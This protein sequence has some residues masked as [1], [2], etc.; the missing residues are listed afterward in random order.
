MVE[1]IELT[2]LPNGLRIV[3]ETVPHVQSVSVGI[4]VGVGERDEEKDVLGISHFIE[5]MVF[6]GTPKRDARQIA[7][8]I[9]SR[10]GSL[11]AFTDKEYTCYYA[12]ALSEH[13]PI[14]MD[15]LTDMLR[16]SLFD[17]EEITREK[18]VVLEEI[19][20]Y[21]DAPEDIVHDLF[22]QTLWRKHPLGRPVIGTVRTVS[23]LERDHI[24]RHIGSHYTPDRV[25]VS[26]AGNIQH[27]AMVDLASRYLGD[28]KGTAPERKRRPPTFSGES[29]L[30]RKRTEQVHFCLGTQAYSQ[31]DD[32]R[33]SL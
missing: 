9:E 16:N 2:T 14:V 20:R 1:N 3:S 7:D 33:Y 10:G 28:M 17:P 30:Q 22:A 15:V 25:V 19:K 5:H 12:R 13:A 32:D 26:A 27:S 23:A 8:E 4:W 21:K 6:K 31:L 11:N 18:G 29:K 24:T